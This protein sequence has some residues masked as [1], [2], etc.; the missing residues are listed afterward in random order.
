MTLPTVPL[1]PVTVALDNAHPQTGADLGPTGG[2]SPVPALFSGAFFG[3]VDFSASFSIQLPKVLLG[4]KRALSP[5]RFRRKED[6]PEGCTSYTG[7]LGSVQNLFSRSLGIAICT[8]NLFGL[9]PLSTCPLAI[10]YVPRQHVCGVGI[11]T[12]TYQSMYTTRNNHGSGKPPPVWSSENSW[13]SVIGAMRLCHPLPF[14]EVYIPD[15]PCMPYLPTLGWF[16]GPYGIH[17]ASGYVTILQV[18]GASHQS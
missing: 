7:G 4:F 14:Q 1:V 10:Q 3:F 8:K 11:A 2:R 15:A 13:T 17:G 5:P 9:C 12:I 18:T 6:Q 16:G